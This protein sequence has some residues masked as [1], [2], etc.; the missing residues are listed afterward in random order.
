MFAQKKLIVAATACY[1]QH[2]FLYSCK[3]VAVTIPIEN[4][5][6]N[7][8]SYYLEKRKSRNIAK[9]KLVITIDNN[10]LECKGVT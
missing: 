7:V 6:T 9:N 3:Y 4:N 2:Y 10:L 8:W 1:I 5:N